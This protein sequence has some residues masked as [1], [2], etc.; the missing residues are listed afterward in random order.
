MNGETPLNDAILS[1]LRSKRRISDKTRAWY[2]TYLHAYAEWLARTKQSVVVAS[3]R[4]D[5]VEAFL[6]EYRQRPTRKYSGGS[7]FD[8]PTRVARIAAQPALELDDVAD[9]AVLDLL[10]DD[11][12]L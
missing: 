7:A 10:I 1:Y 6:S 2:F 3:I 11:A 12:G 4:P 8:L 9:R 5:Y